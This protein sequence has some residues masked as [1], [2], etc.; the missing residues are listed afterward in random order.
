MNPYK[1][2]ARGFIDAVIMP[3]ESRAKIARGLDMLSQKVDNLP[4]KN[5]AT[6]LYNLAFF[7]GYPQLF[8]TVKNICKRWL[9][10]Y[11]SKRI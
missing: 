11:L 7:R 8:V 1:A 5:T 2:A 9:R 10:H 3:E 6:F 4:R